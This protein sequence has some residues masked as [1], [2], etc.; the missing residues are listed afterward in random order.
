MVDVKEVKVSSVLK[1][2]L[3]LSLPGTQG[4]GCCMVLQLCAVRDH[5][6][7]QLGGDPTYTRGPVAGR[8]QHHC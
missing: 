4:E 6:G 1:L 3:I 7:S 5:R 8:V 2:L